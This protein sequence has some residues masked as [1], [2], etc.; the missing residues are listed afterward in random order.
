MKKENN[1]LKKIALLCS[2]LMTAMT[3]L[4]ISTG[5]AVGVTLGTAA[6]VGTAVG[7]HRHKCRKY[8]CQ[9]HR[10]CDHRCDKNRQQR[11]SDEDL[12]NFKDKQELRKELHRKKKD[13]QY[14]RDKLSN[15]KR[16]RPEYKHKIEKHENIIARLEADIEDLKIKLES[17]L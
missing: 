13:L 1:I 14:H 7:V 12:D 11:L 4:T 9:N 15:L 5:G 3:S 6:V 8:G 10:R 16:K 17:F 2:G